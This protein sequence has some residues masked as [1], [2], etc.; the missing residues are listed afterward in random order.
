MVAGGSVHCSRTASELPQ[1]GQRA[2]DFSLQNLAGKRLALKDFRKQG[3]ILVNFWATWCAGC[4][5]E[6]PL[7]NE[8][9]RKYQNKGLE[10]VGI[11]V[12]EER[13][14]VASFSRKHQI[15]YP[16][17]LDSSGDVAKQYGLLAYPSTLIVGGDGTV[18]YQRAAVLDRAALAAIESMLQSR[19]GYPS[20]RTE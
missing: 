20:A 18:L 5:E 9:H 10:I 1:V 2:A 16:V 6:I 11:S 13:E 14:V 19:K 17:V 7:L 4:K 12:E 8:I 15:E 3:V